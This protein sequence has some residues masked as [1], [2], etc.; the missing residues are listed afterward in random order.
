[1]PLTS[2]P[3][4]KNVCIFVML[5]VCLWW[6]GGIPTSS[7]TLPEHFT[8]FHAQSDIADALVDDGLSQ[9]LCTRGSVTT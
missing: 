8:S 5:F 6:A 1:M 9:Q 4:W 3:G 7:N 2:I